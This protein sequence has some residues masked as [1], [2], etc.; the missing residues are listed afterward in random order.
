MNKY[1]WNRLL[2][3]F[4]LLISILSANLTYAAT[5]K[6]PQTKN[7][8][9]T[10]TMVYGTWHGGRSEIHAI[11]IDGTNDRMIAS[12]PE[13]I[14][15][16]HVLSKDQ[17]V[18]IS[19]TDRRDH[20]R[21]IEIYNLGTGAKTTVAEARTG[22][23]IDDIV[24]SPD[25]TYVAWWEVK[26]AAGSDVLMGADSIVYTQQI[27]APRTQTLIVDETAT[28]TAPI[29][30]PLFF[31][32][33]NR[34]YV[35]SF[36]PN[37]GGWNL[38]LFAV[39][40]AEKNPQLTPV[41]KNS[42]FSSD[43]R[44]S[45]NGGSIVFSGYDPTAPEQRKLENNGIL[46]PAMVNPNQLT[47]MDLGNRQKTVIQASGGNVQFGSPIWSNSGG[48]IAF[49]KYRL[50]NPT[51][52][53]F[54]DANTFDGVKI[55][56]I[57]TKNIISLP[58][59]SG[60]ETQI[61]RLIDNNLIWGKATAEPGNL[62]DSY[63]P[64]LTSISVFDVGQMKNVVI[65]GE[66]MLQYIETLEGGTGGML[67]ASSVVPEGPPSREGTIGGTEGETTEDKQKDSDGE[68]SSQP[69]F[70]VLSAVRG[71]QQNNPAD[72][73]ALDAAGSVAKSDLKQVMECI[74][75]MKGSPNWFK[76]FDSPLY[77]Y[78]EETTWVKIKITP[79]TRIFNAEPSYESEWLVLVE[80]TGRIET[81]DGQ[82]FEKISYEYASVI[83]TPPTRG[84]VIAQ[85]ELEA[86]LEN[87][88]LRLGLTGREVSDFV[89]FW[90]EKLPPANYYF[91]SH[92]DSEAASRIISFEIEPRPDTFIQAV[93]YFR[94]L[95]KPTR[96]V[97]PEFEPVPE[98]KGFVAVDWSG[99]IDTTN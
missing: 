98:R 57:P 7:P 61:M 36:I 51:S 84:L 24:I 60:F 31:D 67:L 25:K 59:L 9:P 46:R 33:Q 89:V 74:A 21:T 92:F 68:T 75:A 69:K 72:N 1:C 15:D 97:A 55:F 39:N 99:L 91:V 87:Y 66:G 17:L 18:Y 11:N 12:L 27:N 38:G 83:N 49:L 40:P 42:E 88:A 93:M 14:K 13:N 22:W 43:P 28:A 79:P 23:G 16:V 63:Y 29:H 6:A 78:P 95:S 64:I 19:E 77:L 70:K 10:A 81:P 26:F 73:P 58:N 20:G 34:L 54:R 37:G 90:M 41:L 86:G 80:N 62:G 4:G 71:L 5:T 35:D 2:I 53:I 96:T 47:I 56:D 44:P 30:Y 50:T 52:P 65:K 45:Q 76:C 94:P 85:G 3:L 48:R 32:G 8:P 82:V